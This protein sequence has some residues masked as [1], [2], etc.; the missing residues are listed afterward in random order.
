[1]RYPL[2]GGTLERR[3]SC[4]APQTFQQQTEISERLLR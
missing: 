2:K 4:V 1:M 3:C